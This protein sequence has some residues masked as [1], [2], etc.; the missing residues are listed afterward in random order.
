[1]R[2]LTFTFLLTLLIILIQSNIN[3]TL[4]VSNTNEKLSWGIGKLKE[5][6]GQ[7][8]DCVQ[9]NQE[10]SKYGAT[11]VGT[12]EKHI[13]LTFD[14]GYENG[15]TH[16]IL[17]ILKAEDVQ[18]VFFVTGDYAR[19][20]YDL[21]KRMIEEGHVIGNHSFKHLDYAS[22]SSEKRIED[23]LKLHTF[24]KDRYGYTM[25]LFRFPKGEY[26]ITAL[27]DI[28]R[29][30]YRTLFWSFA[31]YDYNINDQPSDEAALSKLNS[32]LH[33]GA[34][35]LLHSV[36]SANMNVLEEFIRNAKQQE[37]TFALWV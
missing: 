19:E 6:T 14:N 36:S 11:F 24:V 31:Y 10:Y 2:K 37:Y 1:M 21:M 18:A 29:S 16:M 34:I 12:N 8:R 9:A 30:G 33:P 22:T 15:N 28:Q 4:P 23:L 17:D 13:Y 20:Q 25:S 7:P 3:Q 5:E 27:Q 26:S 32:G 35:Y